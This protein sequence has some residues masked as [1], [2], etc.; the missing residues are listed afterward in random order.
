MRISLLGPLLAAAALAIPCLPAAAAED[1]ASGT[2]TVNGVT[3]KVT[4]VYAREVPGF[5]DKNK[6]DIEVI[7]ADMPLDAQALQNPMTR[8]QLAAAGKLHAF[9]MTVN[10]E[11]KPIS[12]SWR[13]SGFKEA[14]PSGL[15]TDD[16][17]TARTADKQT[18]DASY[19]SAKPHKFFGNTFDFDF[20]FRVLVAR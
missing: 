7:L 10:A 15:S 20:A 8:S 6:K 12:T 3:T 11:G 19:K 5:F 4:H 18:L 1:K 13:H 2:L 17:F 14:A 16:V 9:E